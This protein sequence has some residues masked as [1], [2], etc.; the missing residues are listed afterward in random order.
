MK[1]DITIILKFLMIVNYFTV[2]TKQK[3]K[4]HIYNN[5]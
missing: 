1:A 3:I 4:L 5:S 2:W